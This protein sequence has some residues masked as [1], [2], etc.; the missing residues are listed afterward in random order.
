MVG[1]GRGCEYV[2]ALGLVKLE[3]LLKPSR[4]DT[5]VRDGD[6]SLELREVW[7]KLDNV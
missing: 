6:L 3:M 4:G 5:E 2:L 1:Q 7:V